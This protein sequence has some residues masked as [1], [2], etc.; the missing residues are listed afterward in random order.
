[1]VFIV[2]AKVIASGL[3]ESRLT[4]VLHTRANIIGL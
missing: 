1:M 3:P 4:G 2:A